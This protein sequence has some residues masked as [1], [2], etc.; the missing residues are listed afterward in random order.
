MTENF[1]NIE[2][3]DHKWIKR[4]SSKLSNL[5]SDKSEGFYSDLK[6]IIS[7][8]LQKPTSDI[9]SSWERILE[10]LTFYL[11]TT[12][13]VAQFLITV[14][15]SGIEDTEF[16][17]AVK[18]GIDNDQVWHQLKILICLYG[19][20]LQ[21]IYSRQEQNPHSWKAANYKISYDFTNEDWQIVLSIDKFN[22]ESNI[23]EETPTTL[24]ELTSFL[25]GALQE[26]QETHQLSY[27][28]EEVFS[29]DEIDEFRQNFE[30]F[31]SLFEED[32][33]DMDEFKQELK[34]QEIKPE[35]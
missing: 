19:H 35:N 16:L 3:S 12:P 33:E 24:L 22:Q 26:L 10:T 7:E 21:N 14:I 8:N 30:Y 18:S 17:T 5:L 15:A 13:E 4:N 32:A 1:K 23:Y 31:F 28:N 34:N 9:E 20:E 25:L 11:D 29:L 6:D 2:E 27:P